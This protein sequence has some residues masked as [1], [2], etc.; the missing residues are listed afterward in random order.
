MSYKPQGRLRIAQQNRA[1]L[2]SQSRAAARQ[3]RM[4]SIRSGR[5]QLDVQ[6]IIK[7]SGE[8]KGMDTTLDQTAITDDVSVNTNS[9]V[10]NLI[11]QGNGSWNRVGRKVYL[12]SARLKG[13][14]I[15]TFNPVATTADVVIPLLRMVVVWDKQP[16]G[17]VIPTYN[18]IFGTTIQDG[19]EATQ[20]FDSVKYDN[21]G[22]FSVL[23]D[24]T[25]EANPGFLSDAG[26][27]NITTLQIPFDEYI[28]LGNKEVVYSGQSAPMTIS[29]IST[30][31]LYVYFR[32]TVTATDYV[33]TV[34]RSSYCRLRYSD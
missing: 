11:Q 23:R 25:M 22:R 20:V 32:T 34:G 16:S 1:G 31:A 17:N 19:S 2:I 28:K 6:Q 3:R 26:T 7:N 5:Q 12:K 13:Y 14:G 21:M 18:S 27:T 10:L 8:K 24:C 29:D 30:G 9:N 4:Q 15:F 33:W